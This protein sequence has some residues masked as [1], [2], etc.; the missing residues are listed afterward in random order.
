MVQC[1]HDTPCEDRGCVRCCGR[2]VGLLPRLGSIKSGGAEQRPEPRRYAGRSGCVGAT[3]SHIGELVDAGC[4]WFGW[5][6][7][8][9]R[10]RTC[11]ER[12]AESSRW[13]V[14]VV[15]PEAQGEALEARFIS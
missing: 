5:T 11:R 3:Q 8:L 9:G 4:V 13:W 12:R 15:G 1:W 10:G 14:L 2:L 7:F 6:S